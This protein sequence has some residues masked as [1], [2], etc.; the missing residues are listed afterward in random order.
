M[1]RLLTMTL[2]LSFGVSLS[3][4]GGPEYGIQVNVDHDCTETS[5][6]VVVYINNRSNDS[7]KV[8]YEFSA[9]DLDSVLLG[10]AAESF[11][12]PGNYSSTITRQVPVSA[13]PA[14]VG[15]G[16]TSTRI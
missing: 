4:C 10:E 3:A 6:E 14:S 9:H 2:M 12:V 16:T 8:D 11:E 7:F 5:C 15:V 13:K 1:N